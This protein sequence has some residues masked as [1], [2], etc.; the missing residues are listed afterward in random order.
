M[1]IAL[2][3]DDLKGLKSKT[4]HGSIV[5]GERMKI[6]I[7]PRPRLVIAYQIKLLKS[8]RTRAKAADMKRFIATANLIG[9]R[10]LLPSLAKCKGRKT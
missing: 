6:G 5:D 3:Q 8:A 4:L 2:N 10:W 9:E 7:G 1:S